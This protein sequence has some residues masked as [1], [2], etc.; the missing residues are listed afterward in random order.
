ML[1]MKCI[2]IFFLNIIKDMLALILN[3]S[4]KSIPQNEAFLHFANKCS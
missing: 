2:S 4:E 1:F 3:S